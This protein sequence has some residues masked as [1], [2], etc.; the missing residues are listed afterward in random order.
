M[1]KEQ[2]DRLDAL[3]KPRLNFP[4]DFLGMAG[5]IQAGGTVING[6]PSQMSA[7]GVTKPG[8]HY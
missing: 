3:T 5:M 2:V 6:E 8:D 1:T 4:A 7:F